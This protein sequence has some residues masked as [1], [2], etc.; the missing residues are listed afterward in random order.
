MGAVQ[1]K[2]ETLKSLLLLLAYRGPQA[3]NVR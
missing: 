1:Q 2:Q 3:K